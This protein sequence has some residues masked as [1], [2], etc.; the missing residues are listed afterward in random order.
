MS[1]GLM[2]QS[3]PRQ[4]EAEI[5]EAGS[6]DDILNIHINNLWPDPVY[7][8]HPLHSRFLFYMALCLSL[9]FLD[10]SVV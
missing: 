5:T 6:A 10:C 3:F 9:Q 7:R 4:A 8:P 1:D 2:D